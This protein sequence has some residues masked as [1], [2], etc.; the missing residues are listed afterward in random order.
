MIVCVRMHMC[1]KYSTLESVITLNRA[2]FDHLQRRC[3]LCCR[4]TEGSLLTDTAGENTEINKNGEIRKDLS[5]NGY[6]L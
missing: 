5:V 1:V 6:Y 4:G 2:V 3:Y